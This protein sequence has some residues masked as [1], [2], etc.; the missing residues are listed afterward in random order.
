MGLGENRASW[1]SG[2]PR[3]E[4]VLEIPKSESST[5]SGISM[6]VAKAKQHTL[7][8]YQHPPH[9]GSLSHGTEGCL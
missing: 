7:A 6:H 5:Q 3:I 1:V 4:R 2:A 8:L 9:E